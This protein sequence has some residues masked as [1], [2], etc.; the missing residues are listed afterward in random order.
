M[1]AICAPQIDMFE[2]EMESN[3][4]GKTRKGGGGREAKLV[5]WTDRHKL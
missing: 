3:S 2:A 5:E 1:P 4:S